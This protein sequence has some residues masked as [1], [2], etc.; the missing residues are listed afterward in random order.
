M[1]QHYEHQYLLYEQTL[2]G[3]DTCTKY[4]DGMMHSNPKYQIS[5]FLLVSKKD[6]FDVFKD[7][8]SAKFDTSFRARNESNSVFSMKIARKD[9]E[10]SGN[11]LIV[12][13]SKPEIYF[14]FTDEPRL[15]VESVLRPFVNSHYP[16]ISRAFLS[17]SEIRGVLEKL[18][19]TTRGKIIADRITAYKRIAQKKNR[20]KKSNFELKESAITYTGKPYR[21]IFDDA[22]DNDRW[23]DKIQFHLVKN[24]ITG[25][26]GYFSRGGL[27]KFRRDFSI[28]S[29]IIMPH[30]IEL[31]EDKFKLYSNRARTESQIQPSPL[32]IDLD[33]DVFADQNQNV[34]FI[35]SL[36]KMPHA[37]SSVYHSNPYV[38][39]SL[40]D[41]LDGS[42]FDIWVLSVN[43]ITVV[44]QLRASRSSVARLLNHIFE[45]FGEGKIREYD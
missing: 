44:P 40:V 30:I 15:F 25:M 26:E 43:K 37:S 9:S 1:K 10:P 31:V 13:T 14:A 11:V 6:I 27:F 5:M 19:T 2:A 34:R 36:K 23:V 20:K 39:I 4:I 12:K 7:T 35:E 8:D 17:S 3:I 16:E 32:V 28:F 42:S 33:Y 21:E 22:S 38:H 24:D 41:Y 18:E 45:R 29:Q